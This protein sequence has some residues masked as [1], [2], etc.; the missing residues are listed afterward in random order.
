MPQNSIK[1]INHSVASKH[2]DACIIGSSSSNTLAENILKLRMRGVEGYCAF[3]TYLYIPVS[4]HF[5]VFACHAKCTWVG[6]WYNMVD[7]EV[8]SPYIDIYRVNI[9]VTRVFWYPCKM[10][11]CV[12]RPT[13][14]VVFSQG[15][16]ANGVAWAESDASR[17]RVSTRP[18]SV[19]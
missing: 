8:Y 6:T 17:S 10:T 7:C 3:I 5:I 16:S 9:F 4:L 1:I 13:C 2:F 11:P 12:K 19:L 18:L 14:K 15:C